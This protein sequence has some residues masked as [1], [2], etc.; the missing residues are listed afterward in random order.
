MQRAKAIKYNALNKL[1]DM[2]LLVQG[3]TGVHEWAPSDG[4][5]RRPKP[6][7][8]SNSFTIIWRKALR[9]RDNQNSLWIGKGGEAWIRL[10]L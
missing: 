8:H 2:V 9:K 3:Q 6:A 1:G 10:S 4:R 7:C 5:W